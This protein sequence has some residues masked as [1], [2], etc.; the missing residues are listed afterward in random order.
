MLEPEDRYDRLI[1][2][3][4]HLDKDPGRAVALLTEQK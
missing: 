1:L 4:R 2:G 3:K